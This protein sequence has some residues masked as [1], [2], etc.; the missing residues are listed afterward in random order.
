MKQDNPDSAVKAKQGGDA[1][2]GQPRTWW[3]AEA[4][5]WTERM[6][7]ALDNGV[8]G[9]KWFSLVDKAIRPATL[10]A[11]WRKVER[12]KGAAGVDG[13]GIERFA[14]G[15]DRY[16]TELQETLKNGSYRPSP[17]RRVDIPKDGG[18]TRP[19]G[20]PTIK[21]RIVQTALKMTIEPIFEV[22]FRPGSYGFRPG[23][24]CKDALREVDRLLKEGFTHVVDADLKSY[25]DTIPHDKLMA[26]V[27]ETISDGRVLT[28]IDGFLRQE[29]MSDMARWR[30][31]T[32][33]PQG[34]V[35]SPLLANI[36]LHPLDLLMEQ[37]GRR[38]VRYADDFVIVCRTEAE[39]IAALREV[40]A[41]T[42]ANGLT[43]HPDKTRIVD[44]RQP[45]Q[46][47]DFLGYRFEAGRR[48][49]RKKSLG[50]IK[51]KIRAKTK[52]SRGASLTRI[53]ADL[54]PTLRGWFGYFK[55]AA[56]FQL[57]NLDRFVR[58]RLRAV[59]RKQDKRPGFGRSKADHQRWPNAF[60]ADQG[61]F[62]LTTALE[63]A[64]QSR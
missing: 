11:A 48:F 18:Q 55:H 61:L 16:L 57:R 35:L 3:W 51:D 14:A 6:V 7:S 17:V 10:E 60:F 4:S 53:I 33:T 24:S 5:I 46:G 39:A 34:A 54:N 8:K 2:G 25:F 27:G 43:L 22:Q 36:Y 52:R 37:N 64:R 63:H 56:P 30:P 58:R 32:G 28:L 38:M 42:A 12:N 20:I 29:I 40:N 26:R 41:W 1:A 62:T 23:R 13:Q 15:A 44:S 45:G 9:G 21:D 49:V 47:F 19:L 59:L 31:T 50:A